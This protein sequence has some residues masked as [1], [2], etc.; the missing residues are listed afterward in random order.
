MDSSSMSGLVSFLEIQPKAEGSQASRPPPMGETP[1]SQAPEPMGATPT[2]DFPA[3]APNSLNANVLASSPRSVSPS[4]S[5]GQPIGEK[6]IRSALHPVGEPPTGPEEPARPGPMGET[7]IGLTASSLRFA[8]KQ[9]AEHWRSLVTGQVYPARRVLRVD[10]A[11]HSMSL[12]EERF[13][14]TLWKTPSS[15]RFQVVY[16]SRQARRI[17]AGY[18]VLAKVAR[19]NRESVRDL[20]PKMVEKR[21][22]EE[23]GEADLVA[24]RGKT[25]EIFSYQTILARQR[26]AGLMFVVKN[27]RAVEF[28]KPFDPMGETH[29]GGYEGNTPRG[30]T[31]PGGGTPTGLRGDTHTGAMW[32]TPTLIDKDR[33]RD[34]ESSSTIMPKDFLTGLE[35]LIPS[36]DGGAVQR[37]W[38]ETHEIVPDA[39]TE[40]ILYFFD[41]R[42]RLVFRNR[43]I[44]NPMGV[45]LTS[46]K[47]W[48]VARKLHAR[49]EQQR[50][51]AEEV[52]RW[53]RENGAGN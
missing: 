8:P 44:E 4:G 7:P 31:L 18:V 35:K 36:I 52:E 51:D 43:R 47:D 15:E 23:V 53:M 12:G 11:Q 9:I 26:D 32:V 28:V 42:A 24:N 45:L 3:P 40:E 34:K 20:L 39:S 46:I 41:E 25:Y 6:P 21:I 22:F 48:F 10:I 27:G 2:G 14:E 1:P 5:Y 17:C 19:L 38:D 37:I 13:Y 16:E 29:T 49:R 30:E 50:N 33:H